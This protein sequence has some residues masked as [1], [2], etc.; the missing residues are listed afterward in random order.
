MALTATQVERLADVLVYGREQRLVRDLRDA[1]IKSIATRG[2]LTATELYHVERLADLNADELARILNRHSRHIDYEIRTEVWAILQDAQAADAARMALGYGIGLEA[3][4]AAGI[5]AVGRQAAQGIAAMVNRRNLAMVGEANT[6]FRRVVTQALTEHI[7]GAV[8]TER[9]IRDATS[10]LSREVGMV[11]YASG[12]RNHVDV[13]IRRILYTEVPQANAR[14]KTRLLDYYG[15]DLVVTS[16]H[17]TARPSHYPWQGKVFSLHGRTPGYTTLAD[18]TGYGT[19]EGLLGP[20]CRHTFD[21]Y[22][23]G[24]EVRRPELTEAENE[25]LYEATQKQRDLERRIRQTKRDI[26]ALE[27]AGVDTT[28]ARLRLGSQQRQVRELV[29]REDLP[30]RSVRER[31]YGIGSQPRALSADPR[32]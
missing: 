12:V 29:A 8:P 5:S 26:R 17:A 10:E 24:D 2:R 9:I 25:R 19:A 21:I 31:A 14:M 15:H 1:L 6:I 30:R 20:N 7:H 13:A 3:P 27:Q 11:R 4:V 23:P 32:V 22:F 16:S 18:G 28:D